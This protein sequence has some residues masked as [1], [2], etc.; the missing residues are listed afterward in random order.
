MHSSHLRAQSSRRTRR[1]LN[2]AIVG[3]LGALALPAVAQRAPALK[4]GILLP[5]SGRFAA[6]TASAVPGIELAAKLL[7][8]KGTPVQ[9]LKADTRGDPKLSASE[10]ERLIL[11]EKVNG[12]LGPFQTVDVYSAGPLGDHTRCRS[13]PPPSSLRTHTTPDRDTSAA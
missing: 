6:Y 13:C 8:E 10:A 12:V 4:L 9:I 5:L 2:Q 3:A 11:D 1:Q 7:T